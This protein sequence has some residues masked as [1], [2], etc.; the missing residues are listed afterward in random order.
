MGYAR[1]IWNAK[2]R[3]DKEQRQRLVEKKEYPPS[4][5]TYSQYKIKAQTPWLFDVPSVLLRN[6]IVNWYSTYQNF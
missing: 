5:Q 2:N 3:E 4:D 6:S 1:Y